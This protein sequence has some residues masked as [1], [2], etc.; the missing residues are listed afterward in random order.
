MFLSVLPCLAIKATT[1]V[2]ESGVSYS[3]LYSPFGMAAG[4]YMN[5]DVE[6]APDDASVRCVFVCILQALVAWALCR[7]YMYGCVKCM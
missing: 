4:G 3:L 6:P 5:F 1:S 7:A 2:A